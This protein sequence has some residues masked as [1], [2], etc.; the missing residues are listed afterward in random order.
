MI[1]TYR[2]QIVVDQDQ[3][4]VTCNNI[5]CFTTIVGYNHCHTLLHGIKEALD[6]S[7]GYSSPCGGFHIL[8]KLI[9]GVAESGV[10]R[11]SHCAIR[12]HIFF[13]LA[14]DWENKHS[15]EQFNLK[16]KE[17]KL[18]IA[19]LFGRTLYCWNIA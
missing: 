18:N 17:E 16:G 11:S 4:S 7:F 13:P 9:C 5:W 3:W 6:A 12:D 2:E 15:K 10:S 8:P 19:C 1:I 14:I